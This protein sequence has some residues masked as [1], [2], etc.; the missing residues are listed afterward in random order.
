MSDPRWHVRYDPRLVDAMLE[1]YELSAVAYRVYCHLL[2]R[3]AVHRPVT[4]DVDSIREKC[5]LKGAEFH[6]AMGELWTRHLVMVGADLAR[7]RSVLFL[8]EVGE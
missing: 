8:G 6:K 1:P 7:T 2:H 3:G 5:R 4:F